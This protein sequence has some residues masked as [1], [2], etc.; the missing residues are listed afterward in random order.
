MPNTKNPELVKYAEYEEVA[1]SYQKIIWTWTE[2]GIVA[3]DTWE[4]SRI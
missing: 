3:E 1:F 4:A 2:G